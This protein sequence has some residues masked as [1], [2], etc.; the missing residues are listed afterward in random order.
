M[1][2]IKPHLLAGSLTLLLAAC[3]AGTP[4]EL[5][6]RAE[7]AKASASLAVTGTNPAA[8][9]RDTTLDVHVLGSGFDRG[10]QVAFL[11]NGVPDTRVRT[12]STRFVTQ[13]DLVANVT[14]AVDAVPDQY[15]V[16]VMLASGKKGIGTELFAVLSVVDLGVAGPGNGR[17]VNS[18]GTVVGEYQI[19]KSTC[20]HAFVWT[21]ATLARD[22]P[23][24]AGA[25]TAYANGI[26][27][28]GV[29][30]GWSSGGGQ[31]GILRWTPDGSGGY[32]MEQIA[33]PAGYT[34]GESG[35]IGSAGHIVGF[36][37]TTDG[38]WL[39]YLYT[40]GLGWQLVQAGA[41][42]ANTSV[43]I[44]AVNGSG[45]MVGGDCA[46]ALVWTGATSLPTRLPSAD[47][48][49]VAWDLTE[50]GAT[51]VGKAYSSTG[52]RCAVEWQSDGAGGWTSLDLGDL[53]GGVAD[54]RGINGV[55]QVVGFSTKATNGGTLYAF[56]YTPGLGMKALGA[57]RVSDASQALAISGGGSGP[58]YIAGEI[59]QH[60][61]R[62]T[63]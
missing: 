26:N 9:G 28:A 62:W 18:A 61:V 60:A 14:I 11:L 63:E 55:G 41:G 39:G 33:P 38:S 50:D 23:T 57:P 2:S 53:G 27:D 51:I 30:I 58:A 37:L 20:R 34:T 35:A 12:N 46:G 15:D 43:Y 16:Q 59:S 10:S 17:D 32:A 54:A 13:G 21:Q 19:P 1:P 22:L 25:C 44:T 8:A 4:T 31:H 45:M 56:L 24:P 5:D 47:A 7:L 3:E 6:P 49:A 42:C 48:R 40:P 36:F 52:K 29:I